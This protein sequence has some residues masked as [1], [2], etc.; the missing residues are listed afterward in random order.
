MKKIFAFLIIMSL[1]MM[2][3]PLMDVQA[4]EYNISVDSNVY[5]KYSVP[6]AYITQG[7]YFALNVTVTDLG[8]GVAN[9]KIEIM[10]DEYFKIDTP[11]AEKTLAKGESHAFVIKYLG[12]KNKVP[13]KVTYGAAPVTKFVNLPISQLIGGDNTSSPNP[14]TINNEPRLI[15]ENSTIP[16]ANAGDTLKLPLVVTNSSNYQAS[17]VTAKVIIPADGQSPLDM[18]SLNLTQKISLLSPS[19]SETINFTLKTSANAMK[20]TYPISIELKYSNSQGE[21]FTSTETVYIKITNSNTPPI[22]T[23]QNITASPDPVLGGG[24]AKVSFTL[25]NIGDTEAREIKVSL[26][27]LKKDGFTVLKGSSNKYYASMDK[28]QSVNIVY[29]LHASE[30]M[31]SGNNS[32]GIKLEYKDALNKE[33][34]DEQTIFINTQGQSKSSSSKLSIKNISI[35]PAVIQANESFKLNFAVANEGKVQAENV[36]VVVKPEEGVFL[37]TQDTMV[38]DT[39]KPGTTEK[40]EFVLFASDQLKSKSYNIQISVEYEDASKEGSKYTVNQYASVYVDSSNNKLTPK[41]II[42]RY[43]FEPGIVRAGENFTLEMSFLNTSSAKTIRNIKIFLTGIDLDKEG[44]IVFTPINSSNTFFVD[45]IGPKQTAAR[46]LEMYTIPDAMPMTYTV[47]ANFEYQD[48]EGTEYKATELI[49]IPV[50]Q[51]SKMDAGD[52]GIPPEF[53]IGQPMPVNIQYFNKGKTKL[54]NLMIKVE[55]DFEI[56]NKT[57]Y[58][59]NFESGASDNFEAMIIPMKPGTLNGRFIFTFDDPSGESQEFIRDFSVNA[60][61]MPIMEPP[62]DMPMEQPSLKDKIMSKTIKNKFFWIGIAVFG[63]AAFTAVKLIKKK[64]NGIDLDE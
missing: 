11:D 49:G 64:K 28:K 16:T 55:G 24:D 58:I 14:P 29:D 37:K 44:K 36:K 6:D 31:E 60:V 3:M 47:T 35:N 63:A 18:D 50:I 5:I 38:I 62:I 40:T 19:K 13:V 15:I 12:T 46:T 2:N 8:A 4:A 25:S 1:L 53:F 22:L 54:S 21:V 51:Q 52:L 34:T 32:I 20:K 30:K 9:A 17:N 42:N 57:A 59:G 41:I 23:I 61:E 7:D 43:S 26:V 45:S 39:I 10:S 33:Y 27:D 56:Q 48:E